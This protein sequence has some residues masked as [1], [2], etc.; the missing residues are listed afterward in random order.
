MCVLVVCVGLVGQRG[1]GTHVGML[2]A[3]PSPAHT[4]RVQEGSL[5]QG[6][7]WTDELSYCQNAKVTAWLGVAAIEG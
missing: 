7:K 6:R 3:R 4:I 2:Y 1:G 5:Q